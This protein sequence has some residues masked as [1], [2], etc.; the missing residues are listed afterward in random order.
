MEAGAEEFQ[1]DYHP[2]CPVGLFPI[3]KVQQEVKTTFP[4]TL[5]SDPGISE[6]HALDLIC[7]LVNP[8]LGSPPDPGPEG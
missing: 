3:D 7:H 4:G 2:L 6:T 8:V 5:R 1:G